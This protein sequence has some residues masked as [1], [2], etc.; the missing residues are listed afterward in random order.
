MNI[1][2]IERLREAAVQHGEVYDLLQV[3]ATSFPFT[4][5]GGISF[6][7]SNSDMAYL[8]TAVLAAEFAEFDN[9]AG[10]S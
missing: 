8:R 10:E 3:L 1:G 5:D 9:T 4:G 7:G 2:Q 6:H